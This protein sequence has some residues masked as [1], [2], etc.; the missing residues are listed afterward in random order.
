VALAV[1]LG[2]RSSSAQS[3]GDRPGFRVGPV[4]FRPRLLLR[5]IGVDS[6]V[7]NE[8]TNPKSDF[9]LTAAP[10]VEIATH[11]GRLKLAY[12]TG[13][14][15]VYFRTYTSQRARNGSIGGRAELDLTWLKPFASFSAT[16]TSARPNSEIDV[17]VEHHPW[18]YTAG[19]TVK[20]ASRTSIGILGRRTRETYDEHAEFRGEDLAQS[21]DTTIRTYETSFNVDLTPFTT[22]SIVGAKEEQR[23]DYAS[24]RNADSIRVAPTLTFSPLGLVTG[25]A[26]V[27]YRRFNGLDP[28]LPDYSGIVASGNVGIL[29]YDRYKVDTT[30]THDIRYSYERALPYYIVSGLRATL[31]LRTYGPVDVRA[32]GGR[33]SMDYRTIDGPASPGPDVLALYGGGVGYRLGTRA[34]VAVDVER[35]HRSSE[36]ADSREYRNNRVLA[37][38]TWGAVN[39]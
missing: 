38:F 31:S 35:S 13:A 15:F 10:D 18:T 27:G 30:F 3:E 11:P 36:R 9:T 2:P 24:E 37:L 32:L 12:T 8:P 20:I 17:R 39:R 5:D 22:F 26:S 19:T 28:S 1:A 6:N 34:R 25:S 21:L 7:F 33:E 4:E 29:F 23:F 14:E 16:E